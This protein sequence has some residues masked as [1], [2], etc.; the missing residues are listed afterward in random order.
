MASP[1]DARGR[2]MTRVR[3]ATSAAPII[4][5]ALAAL[6]ACASNHPAGARSS[7]GTS[8]AAPSGSATQSAT[9]TASPSGPTTMKTYA[10]FDENGRLTVK[11]IRGGTGTC[12]ATSIAVPLSGV[13]RCLEGNTI[14]DPCFAPVHESTPPSVACFDDPWTPGELV[15][16]HSSLPVYT[17]VL[18]AGNPWGLELENGTHCVSVTGA[19]PSL[20]DIDLSYRCDGGLVA[21]ITTADNGTL[22]AHVGPPGGPLLPVGVPAAWRGRSYRFPGTS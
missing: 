6:T 15:T 16:L 20:G 3:R 14:L 18:T 11:V 1:A 21:G 12:F 22:T 19:I 4:V 17:P 2:S 7:A 10:P 5:V 8:S 9:S 13:Y